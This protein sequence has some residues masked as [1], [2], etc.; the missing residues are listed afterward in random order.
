MATIETTQA[1]DFDD[2]ATWVGGVVPGTGDHARIRHPTVIVNPVDAIW[3]IE[4]I[5]SL[6][7]NNDITFDDALKTLFIVSSN[8]VV[9]TDASLG[10]IHTL[11]SAGGLTPNNKWLFFKVSN[12]GAINLDYIRMTGGYWRLGVDAG[13]DYIH[14]NTGTNTRITNITPRERVPVIDEHV[15]IGRSKARIYPRGT[16][17]GVMKLEG[18]LYW[19]DMYWK[20]IENWKAAR[21]KLMFVTEYEHMPHCRIESFKCSPRPGKLH[22]P[23]S[24]TLIEDE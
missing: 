24:M 11:K 18:Y 8:G 21:T 20:K 22:V 1:G 10:N 2:T 15:C 12:A 13:S 14:F 4:V 7:I 17:A 16:H 5:S 6:A 23:F 3:N 9:T 19:P